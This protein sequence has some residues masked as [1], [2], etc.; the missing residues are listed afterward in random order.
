MVNILDS[1]SVGVKRAAISPKHLMASILEVLG[2][3]KFCRIKGMSSVSKMYAKG[4]HV[5]KV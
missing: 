5:K 2:T 4:I 1:L 3:T